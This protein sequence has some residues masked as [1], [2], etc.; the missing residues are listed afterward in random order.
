MPKNNEISPS[1]AETKISVQEIVSSSGDLSSI[2]TGSRSQL[3]QEPPAKQSA[4]MP[5]PTEQ[6]TA[7]AITLPPPE[8][9]PQEEARQQEVQSQ[10]IVKKEAIQDFHPVQMRTEAQDVQCKDIQMHMDATDR[11]VFVHAMKKEAGVTTP[12]KGPGGSYTVIPASRKGNCL[13]Y[14]IQANIQ[15]K[16]LRCYASC[17]NQPLNMP[18]VNRQIPEHRDDKAAI[19]SSMSR[20]DQDALMKALTYHGPVSWRGLSGVFYTV[21]PVRLG[22]PCREY[23]VQANIQGRIFQYLESNCQ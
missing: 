9:I 19:L 5:V 7:A 3:V 11:A 17:T 4:A 12:W 21:W 14:S 18:P 16:V 2:L 10:H 13:E 22:N 1:H 6:E 8:P 23:T 15:G 20:T